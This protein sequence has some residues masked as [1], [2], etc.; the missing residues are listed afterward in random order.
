[1]S[2]R[3]RRPPLDARSLSTLADFARGYL[4]EDVLAEHGSAAG[5]AAAFCQDAS[6]DERRRLVADL[7]RLVE[8]ART[9]PAVKLSRFFERDLGAAWTPQSL[10]DLQALEAVARHADD[11]R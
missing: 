8:V 3:T 6:A 5:A 10:S 9:W 4:H 2:A 7:A 1:M 11:E